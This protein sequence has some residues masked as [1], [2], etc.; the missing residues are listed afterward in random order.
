MLSS[1][2]KENSLIFLPSEGRMESRNPR[3]SSRTSIVR[4]FL[5]NEFR[6]TRES[7]AA[8]PL[9]ISSEIRRRK[10][11]IAMDFKEEF[12]KYFIPESFRPHNSLFRR[13]NTL[14]YDP[15]ETSDK[16]LIVIHHFKRLMSSGKSLFAL[17]EFSLQKDRRRSKNKSEISV[18]SYPKE[19]SFLDPLSLYP[20]PMNLGGWMEFLETVCCSSRMRSKDFL[21]RS[22]LGRVIVNAFSTLATILSITCGSKSL[23]TDLILE[24][25]CLQLFDGPLALLSKRRPHR[26]AVKFEDFFLRLSKLKR[27]NQ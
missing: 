5:T 27:M 12:F 24:C 7:S 17:S 10:F 2:S 26:P 21:L 6:L 25:D 4:S 9:L 11:L 23:R 13:R 1:C 15:R 8:R 3:I 19:F 22:L 14:R 16:F 18:G 20:I